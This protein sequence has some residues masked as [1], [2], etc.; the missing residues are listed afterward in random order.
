MKALA[1]IIAVFLAIGI[2]GV[3]RSYRLPPETM[4]YYL[5]IKDKGWIKSKSTIMDAAEEGWDYGV[6]ITGEIIN[7]KSRKKTGKKFV[8]F[9]QRG[10]N[11]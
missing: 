6:L 4:L 9:P 7:V 2:A 5:R 1:I 3:M 10:V 11:R 8:K